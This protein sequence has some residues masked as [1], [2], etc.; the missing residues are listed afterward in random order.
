[1]DL[2][3]ERLK[4]AQGSLPISIDAEVGKGE[5]PEQPGPDG[6]LMIGAVPL[7]R[8]PGVVPLVVRVSRAQTA[9]SVAGQQLPRTGVDDTFLL[10]R[11]EWTVG[12][13][14]REYLV[15]P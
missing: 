4:E 9:Q 12:Q 1:M 11:R 14:N 13:R 3:P 2:F 15:R 7:R 10:F 5:W 6:P 8:S